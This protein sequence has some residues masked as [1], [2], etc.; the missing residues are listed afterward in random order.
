MSSFNA[1]VPFYFKQCSILFLA[2]FI[3]FWAMF[4]AHVKDYMCSILFLAVFPALA[5]DYMWFVLYL[6]VF[7]S[8]FS[9]VCSIFSCV[10]STCPMSR[11]SV[12]TIRRSVRRWSPRLRNSSPS[13]TASPPARSS[14]RRSYRMRTSQGSTSFRDLTG[15]VNFKIWLRTLTL[16]IQLPCRR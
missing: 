7:H 5:N 8:I 15:Y 16:E 6:I 12:S 2:E 3:L 11:T 1:C 14:S 9:C 10:P 4:L 13:S